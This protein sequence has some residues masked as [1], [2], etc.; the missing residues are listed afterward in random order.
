MGLA[1]GAAKDPNAVLDATLKAAQTQKQG[2]NK[3]W[4]L[5]TGPRGLLNVR[6]VGQDLS[7]A[8]PRVWCCALA[9]FRQDVLDEMRRLREGGP[10]YPGPPGSGGGGKAP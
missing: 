1:P 6:P 2:W 5:A 4:F 3:V 10:G 8:G 9:Q 7:P